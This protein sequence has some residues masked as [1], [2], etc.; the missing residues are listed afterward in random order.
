MLDIDLK[1]QLKAYLERLTRPLELVARHRR[2]RRIAR[3]APV[4]RRHRRSV[5]PRRHRRRRDRRRARPVIPDPPAWHEGRVRFAGLP[6]GHEFT[7]LVLALLHVGGHPPK[8]DAATIDRIRALDGD[9]RFETY[10]SLSCQ[11]CPDVVQALNLMS[12]INPRIRNVTIDG[13]LFREEVESKEVIAVPSVFLNGEPFG[14][15]RMSLEEILAK[16]DTGAGARI[17]AELERTRPVRRA[18]RRRWP[19]WRGCRRLRRAQGHSRGH[20]RRALRRPG[21]GHA[22]HRELPIG[23]RDRGA[24]VRRRA[25]APRAP[26][27]RRVRSVGSGRRRWSR[28]RSPAAWSESDSR[29]AP[30]CKVVR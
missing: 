1:T 24:D 21:P 29:A 4:A 25:R 18:D 15:G 3:P 19:G 26:L 27:R 16:L 11:N 10:V 20:R 22:R 13:A 9:Y 8:V 30:R 17:A 14:Q 12:A 28:P 2:Q 23:T 6:L 5:R 7:S